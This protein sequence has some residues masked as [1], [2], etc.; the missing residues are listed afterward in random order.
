M[1]PKD[2]AV[3]V[4]IE[5][6]QSM[7]DHSQY[8]RYRGEDLPPAAYQLRA[9]TESGRGVYTFCM[10]PGGFVVNA[11]TEEGGIAVNG[12]SYAK[13]DGLHAN[14]AVVA[15]VGKEDFIACNK[16]RD[17]EDVPEVF[18]GMEFQRRLER[19]AF[20]LGSGKVPV[21]SLHEFLYGSYKQ[22]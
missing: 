6:P 1:E 10:C 14:S 21:S 3:G 18:W 5:H 19:K 15:T 7:I 8:G 20:E 22:H 17:G 11:S 2:F 13:R 16:N 12:M 9:H 4:R